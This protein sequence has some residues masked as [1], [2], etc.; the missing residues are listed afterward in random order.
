MASG[1]HAYKDAVYNFALTDNYF[2]DFLSDQVE[3]LDGLAKGAVC[4]HFIILWQPDD[5]LRIFRGENEKEKRK[6]AITHRNG[7]SLLSKSNC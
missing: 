6:G 4:E 3:M 2:A 1:D 5:T 7:R